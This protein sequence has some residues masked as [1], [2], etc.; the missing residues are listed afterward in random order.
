LP[1][2]EDNVDRIRE[3]LTDEGFEY[4]AGCTLVKSSAD[5]F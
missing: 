5:E 3:I 1:A 2:I 4:A